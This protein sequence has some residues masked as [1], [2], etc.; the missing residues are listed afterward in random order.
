MKLLRVIETGRFQRLGST[1]T[2]SAGVRVLSATNADLEA[3][4][5]S[6]RFREDLYYR[7]NVIEIHVPPLA[8]RRDDIAPLTEHFLAARAVLSAE[9]HDALLAHAWPG[10][11]RELKNVIERACLLAS[12]GQINVSDLDLPARAG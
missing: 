6:G 9:A 2:R 11:V 8:E 4:V 5:A 10:N 7:L 3:M 12:Q 1:R